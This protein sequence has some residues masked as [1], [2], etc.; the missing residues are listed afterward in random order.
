MRV[1]LMIIRLPPA[2]VSLFLTILS[3]PD[4]S[5]WDPRWYL[6]C[7]ESYDARASNVRVCR[8]RTLNSARSD[9][10]LSKSDGEVLYVCL[11]TALRSDSY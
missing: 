7:K 10:S 4:W 9:P 2:I 1:A 5:S 8:G 6:S 11:V 3:T